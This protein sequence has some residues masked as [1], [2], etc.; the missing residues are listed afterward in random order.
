MLRRIFEP[1]KEVKGLA[2]LATVMQASGDRGQVLQ[3]DTD[4]VRLFLEDGTALVLSQIPPRIRFADRDKC[5]LRR[6]RT[7]EFLLVCHQGVDFGTICV[8]RVACNTT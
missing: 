5:G 2:K 6:L 3:A 1:R 7:V 4:V 8:S